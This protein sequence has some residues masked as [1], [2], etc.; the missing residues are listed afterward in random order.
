M[1]RWPFTRATTISRSV[2]DFTKTGVFRLG[3][4]SLSFLSRSR[5]VPEPKKR[6]FHIDFPPMSAPSPAKISNLWHTRAYAIEV[7]VRLHRGVS[8]DIPRVGASAEY[9]IQYCC[10]SFMRAPSD[11]PSLN[12]HY[13][14]YIVIIII[15]ITT[16]QYTHVV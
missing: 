1:N 6:R 3:M 16:I 7:R 15:T 14:R 12:N 8:L 2:W 10:D 13:W 4:T 9:F 5:T 11:N